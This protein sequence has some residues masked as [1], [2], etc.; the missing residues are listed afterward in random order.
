MRAHDVGTQERFGCQDR[1]IDVRLRREIDDRIEAARQRRVDR[2]FV[3]NIGVNEAIPRVVYDIG[4][5]C[6]ISRIG[7][8]IVIGNRYVRTLAQHQPD[9]VR[10]DETE[11]PG[12]EPPALFTAV[13][14]AHVPSGIATA[15]SSVRKLLPPSSE[16]E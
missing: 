11:A 15:L 12:Y 16:D 2:A 9:E 4:D 14:G 3:A 7:H 6:R 1:T 5:V 10:P 8:R 13:R